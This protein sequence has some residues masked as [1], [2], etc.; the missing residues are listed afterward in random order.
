MKKIA[1]KIEDAAGFFQLAVKDCF[2]IPSVVLLIFETV[3]LFASDQDEAVSKFT[4]DLC[5][6][7]FE[8][9]YELDPKA[10]EEDIR[11]RL[12]SEVEA[13]RPPN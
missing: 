4:A 8:R 9:C 6:K 1:E 7:A 5:D 11:R 12:S 3:N 2:D 10:N 13:F